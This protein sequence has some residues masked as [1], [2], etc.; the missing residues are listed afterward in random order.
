MVCPIAHGLTVIVTPEAYYL[1][2]LAILL[3]VA[4]LAAGWQKEG[5]WLQPIFLIAVAIALV[6]N[7]WPVFLWPTAIAPDEGLWG[8]CALKALVD[9]VPWR[10][11][12]PTTSGPL[13]CDVLT[14]PAIFGLPIT[15]FSIRL[16]GAL[17][18]IGALYAL[19]FAV[20]WT[21]AASVARIATVPV[22]A[23]LCLTKNPDLLHY[24]SEH[25]PIFFLGMITAAGAHC[26]REGCSPRGRITACI[27]AGFSGGSIVFAKLQTMPIAAGALLSVFFALLLTRRKPSRI[28]FEILVLA[29]SALAVPALLLGAVWVAGDMNDAFISYAAMSGAMLEARKLIEGFSYP[30]VR[31]HTMF[32]VYAVAT[33]AGG[34]A[35]LIRDRFA[36]ERRTGWVFA[37]AVALIATSIFVVYESHRPY[38]HY[39]LLTLF[40]LSLGIAATIHLAQARFWWIRTT[41]LL[42]LGYATAAVGAIAACALPGSLEKVRIALNVSSNWKSAEG[43]AI[44]R[45]ARPGDRI[46][47]WGW[48]AQ[49]YVETHTVM[50]TR[51]AHTLNQSAPSR[52]RAYFRERYLRDFQDHPPV[53]IVEAVGPGYF[54]F[55]DRAAQG[56]ETFPA[57]A[58]IVREQYT[59]REEIGSTRI[60]VAKGR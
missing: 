36:I 43:S 14:L 20:K 6:V 37:T 55:T 2:S 46:T 35:L 47:I 17:M 58:A 28:G 3:V 30:V 1:A 49:L 45:S 7:R 5:R 56:I 40:P 53:V 24:S 29:A 32:L 12:D 18:L 44:E 60:F 39:L 16:C 33:L 59:L 31:E 34:A 13:N 15:F 42:G 26:F 9:W 10:G 19:Y 11:F 8:A 38:G 27:V 57:L 52:Y 51:D 41:R 48:A 21:L 4:W 25:L 23:L 54:T 22:L 50:A